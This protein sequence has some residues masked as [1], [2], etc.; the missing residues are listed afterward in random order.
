MN[1]AATA[2][3]AGSRL[4][5]AENVA[6]GYE[7]GKPVLTAVTAAIESGR[8]TGIVGPNGSGKSTLL[9]LMT[10]L[11]APAQGRVH[12]DGRP[13]MAF[14]RVERARSLAFLPQSINP[15][16]AL[17]VF[18]VVCL[19]RYPHVGALRGLG[20]QDRRVAEQC[21]RETNTAHLRSRDF[22][23]LS[24]GERQ[25]VLLASILAQ[26]PNLLLLDEPTS[27]LDIHHQVEIFSLLR[28]LSRRGYGVAVVTHDLN[29]AAVFCDTLL[30]LAPGHTGLL[31]SGPPHDVLTDDLLSRAYDAPIRVVRHPASGAPLVTADVP[32][33][34]DI[35]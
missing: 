23:T 32:P 8:V 5:V 22:S 12:L 13:L 18:E 21:L 25:R 20:A 29:L 7:P 30:L 10:G 24:G 31:A 4:L 28:R 33:Q 35:P 34:E 17:T 11:L 3:H 6:Y 27:A 9:R 14:T 2:S 16:F 19:G 26:D 15:A 1:H